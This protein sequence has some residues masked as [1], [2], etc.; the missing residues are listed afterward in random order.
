MC[1]FVLITAN[2]HLYL[3]ISFE[4]SSK[5]DCSSIQKQLVLHSYGITTILYIK[6][7]HRRCR[8]IQNIFC[9]RP[10]AIWWKSS[11]QTSSGMKK[12]EQEFRLNQ[13]CMYFTRH[14]WHNCRLLC[15]RKKFLLP[16]VPSHHHSYKTG[17]T[18]C[19][20]MCCLFIHIINSASGCSWRLLTFTPYMV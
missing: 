2:D 11:G 14:S 10:L 15:R 16:D 17:L 8:R 13:P 7:F 12:I 18:M 4:K 19:M 5:G 20:L 9:N 1:N 3:V 6:I